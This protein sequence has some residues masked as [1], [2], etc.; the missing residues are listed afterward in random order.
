MNEMACDR[1][2]GAF[3]M[4]VFGDGSAN[5][6]AGLLA[7]LEGCDGCRA[8]VDE[9][10]RTYDVLGYADP[11]AVSSTASIPP[12]LTEKVLQDLRRGAASQRR[13]R[14]VRASALA[15]G[16]VAAA[17]ILVAIFN[18][19][20]FAPTQVQ[21]SVALQGASS[22]SANA[23]LVAR[24]WGTSITL[25]E[26][27]LP[28]GRVYTV[29]MRTGKGIW[30]VAGTYRSVPGKRVDVNMACAIS[31]SQITGVRVSDASGR[32][33]LGSSGVAVYNGT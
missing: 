12:D 19:T 7:H 31:L 3:A 16:L 24:S 10:K 9:M 23:V 27:G 18:N 15:G 11:A 8:V 21:R 25:H 22:V 6:E 32:L 5:E 13:G 2:H 20:T 4:H 30:W 29:S 14:R 28:G 17:I 26:Q 33:V 1:W